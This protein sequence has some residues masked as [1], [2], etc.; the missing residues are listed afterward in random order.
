MASLTGCVRYFV[1]DASNVFWILG[2]DGEKQLLCL[3]LS[4]RKRSLLIFC[5]FGELLVLSLLRLKLQS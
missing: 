3:E 4:I 5:S 1:D 2:F